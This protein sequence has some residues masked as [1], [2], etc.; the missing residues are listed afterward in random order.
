[1]LRR[2]QRLRREYLYRRS[3]RGKEKEE[4]EKKRKVQQALKEGKQLP[5]E[6]HEEAATLQR[7][8]ALDDEETQSWCL[9]LPCCRSICLTERAMHRAAE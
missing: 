6:L 5:K 4:Y 7:E 9:L 1:M 3:L 2:N 8:V